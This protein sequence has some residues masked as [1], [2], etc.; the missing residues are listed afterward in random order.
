M[1]DIIVKDVQYHKSLGKF[2][3]MSQDAN[4]HCLE[5]L[6]FK[7]TMPNVNKDM[8]QLTHQEGKQYSY[9][10]KLLSGFL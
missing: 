5:W 9:S 8:E 4:I 1:A 2:K 3:L 6:I 7:L 10:E